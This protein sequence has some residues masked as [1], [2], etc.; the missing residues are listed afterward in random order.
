MD[1]FLSKGAQVINTDTSQGITCAIVT[2]DIQSDRC[3]EQQESKNTTIKSR[4]L[5]GH[6][7]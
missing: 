6:L 2:C 7:F 1:I 4:G 5:I 3:N